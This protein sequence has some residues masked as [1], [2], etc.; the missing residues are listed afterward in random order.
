MIAIATTTRTG[1]RPARRTPP[2]TPPPTQTRRFFATAAAGFTLIEVL[3]SIIILALGLLGI[4]VVFPVVIRQQ[5]ISTDEVAGILMA[6]NT[7]DAFQIR[8]DN[9]TVWSKWRGYMW[10]GADPYGS[11][12]L[13]SD[14]YREG[15]WTRPEIDSDTGDME[16]TPSGNPATV[17]ATERLI[18]SVESRVDDDETYVW[19]M[20]MQPVYDGDD[21]IFNDRMR[22]AVFVRR[23]DAR[24][25]EDG[26]P[27]AMESN[28][29]LPAVDRRANQPGIEYA[30]PLVVKA[31]IQKDPD[32]NTVVDRDHLIWTDDNN[33]WAIFSQPGQKLVDAF[34]NVY[35]VQ[36]GFEDE[37]S[38]DRKVRISP[39]IPASITIGMVPLDLSIVTTPQPA[40]AVYTFEVTP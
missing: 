39:P 36:R 10:G 25:R 2:A 14:P 30:H 23:I 9:N 17:N 16:L 21:N 3:I 1:T 29:R 24:T 13:P 12:T 5:R 28:T 33:G 26:L 4:G 11:P 37:D 32:D 35:T 7:A 6:R 34:G 18:F 20:A 27:A 38:G 19:D 15:V 40:V 22:I 8:L 31:R